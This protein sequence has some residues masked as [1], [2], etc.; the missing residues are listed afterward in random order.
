MVLA[1]RAGEQGVCPLCAVLPLQA[2]AGWLSLTV[3]LPVQP[4]TLVRL[5]PHVTAQHVLSRKPPPL[6]AFT[7]PAPP[8]PRGGVP[9]LG[10]LRT[11]AT[12]NNTDEHCA[13]CIA[14]PGY[15]Y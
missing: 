15:P 10:F 2:V 12:T 13:S 11:R 9:G 8:D 3:L 6:P 5:V 4:L 1:N 7:A 14:R